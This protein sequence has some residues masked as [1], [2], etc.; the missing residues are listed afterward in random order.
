MSPNAETTEEIPMPVSS[1]EIDMNRDREPLAGAGPAAPVPAGT[2][3]E[4]FAAQVERAPG[5]VAVVFG[6]HQLT[7]DELDQRA[8][9]LGWRLHDLGIG[10]DVLVGI[11]LPRGIDMVVAVLAVL[12][13]GGAYVPLDP[14]Y[15]ADRLQFMLTD[16][17]APVLITT[18]QLAPTLPDHHATTITPTTGDTTNKVGPPPCDATA[19]HL[20]YAIYTSGSTGTPKLVA[21]EHLGVVN[22]AFYKLYPNSTADRTAAHRSCS[23]TTHISQ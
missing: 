18:N 2:I 4:L 14:D 3:P 17:A 8:N 21:V 11:C 6:D 22:H 16:T 19:N 5:A 12:K 7:Y 23:Y 13:A 20:A 15:P 1:Q 9:E 10:P